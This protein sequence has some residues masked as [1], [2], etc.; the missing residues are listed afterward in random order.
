MKLTNI[1]THCLITVYC[2]ADTGKATDAP[3][4]GDQS[5]H[6]TDYSLTSPINYDNSYIQNYNSIIQAIT[7]LAQD[8]SIALNNMIAKITEWMRLNKRNKL[9]DEELEI[10]AHTS[11][12]IIELYSKLLNLNLKEYVC[13]CLQPSLELL[14]ALIGQG[15]KDGFFDYERKDGVIP[16]GSITEGLYVF[17]EMTKAK[18]DEITVKKDLSIKY[19]EIKKDINCNSDAIVE[20]ISGI[21]IDCKN[22]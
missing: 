11:D 21:D 22:Y 16:Y 19:D 6:P 9:C 17:L 1:L 8:K 20:L 5:Q 14:G 18:L 13:Q 4:T 10:D 7:K 3:T 2:T 15:K 12:N